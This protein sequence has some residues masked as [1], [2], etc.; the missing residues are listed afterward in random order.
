M[1]KK[2]ISVFLITFFVVF[3]FSAI[4][5]AGTVNLP[6]TS[7]TTCYDTAG[8]QISCTCTGQDGEIQAGVAW[9]NPR[10]TTNAD[11]TITDNLTGLVWAANGNLMKLR[12]PSFD[13]DIIGYPSTVGDGQVTWCHALDYVAK[14]NSENYLGQHDWRLPN[15]NE[16]ESLINAD[17]ANPV[18]WLNSQGFANVQE[19]YWSSTKLPLHS[20]GWG[21]SFSLGYVGI[22][23]STY[24]WP[25]RGGQSGSVDPIYPANIWQ[26]GQTIS[27]SS[28]LCGLIPCEVEDDGAQQKGV[29]WPNPRF[30]N[31]DGTTP[32]SG[33]VVV[34]QLTG[35]M[36]TKNANL[37][38]GTMLW[39][40]ALDY[41]KTIKTGGYTGWRMPNRKELIS[42]LDYS[43]YGPALPQ[44]H[45]FTNVQSIN[46]W[47][48]TSSIYKGSIWA[49]RIYDG[50][51]SF[52]NKSVNGGL[53]IWP[54]RSEDGV[55]DVCDYPS[56]PDLSVLIDPA[57][58]PKAIVQVIWNADVN[59]DQKA[60]LVSGKNAMLRAD[61]IIKNIDA[62]N[63]EQPVEV[64]LTYYNFENI[65]ARTE[66]RKVKDLKE[67]NYIDFYFTPTGTGDQQIIVEIDP[68]SRINESDEG[69]NEAKLDFT[70]H[71][72]FRMNTYYISINSEYY[73][74]PKNP[75]ETAQAFAN[76]I[77][78]TYPMP[79]CFSDECPD[80]QISDTQEANS[81]EECKIDCINNMLSRNCKKDGIGE[82]I[83]NLSNWLKKQK[84]DKN[85]RVVGI[86]SADYF[87]K[88]KYCLEDGRCAKGI[89]YRSESQAVLAQEGY[90][91]VAAHEIGHTWGF[92]DDY[93]L[94]Q[95]CKKVSK[96]GNP[97]DGFWVKKGKEGLKEEAEIDNGLC[98]MGA[99]PDDGKMQWIDINHFYGLWNKF[100][101][102]SRKTNAN[103]PLNNRIINDGGEIN[104]IIKTATNSNTLLINGIIYIDG[105]IKLGQWYSLVDAEIDTPIPGAYS[106]E[107]IGNDGQMLQEVKF[108]V[109]FYM[110]ADPFGIVETNSAPFVLSIPY[111]DNTAKIEIK[112]NDTTLVQVNP[113]I[114]LLDDAVD[115]IPDSGFKNE[116][117]NRRATL[118]SKIR[119]IEKML[120]QNNK[121]G[122]LQKLQ[123]DIKDKFQK[124]I[125]DSYPLDN[126]LQL[127]KAEVLDLV[128][129]TIERVKIM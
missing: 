118:H 40:Q 111:P 46:Y 59:N 6:K 1:F 36:W 102:N 27:N 82:D 80:N 28:C 69:N 34:D 30:T 103:V 7:Q 5:L 74:F 94:G 105:S 16:L 113:T 101:I 2:I 121:K 39:Q 128:N 14:L 51:V 97:A 104:K 61:I 24:T 87:E 10:F 115:L 13:N 58:K 129:A 44:G 76:F 86:V 109:P 48:S 81:D 96:L 22:N 3:S 98:F 66:T 41:V 33:D 79:D 89:K 47:S 29:A 124:W 112:H 21:V 99:T 92:E 60:D 18:A 78:G 43:K 126:P 57:K 95:D 11:T 26:T 15:V 83:I 106:I 72:M 114:K 88:H 125:K 32:I 119:E 35:L 116:P 20:V 19:G 49:V 70:V 62:L 53:P 110:N 91:S 67:Q 52:W 127:S 9:P 84:K 31:P 77:E 100:E 90:N 54:V 123:N 4:T 64:K 120:A 25:V 23:S 12:D 55:G 17:S 45:P 75:Q 68:N 107:L 50:I 42:L 38:N 93:T 37:A 117:A 85:E 8:N 73:H 56:V 63:E 71:K 65:I 108:D 122:A